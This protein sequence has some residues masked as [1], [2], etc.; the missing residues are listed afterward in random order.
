MFLSWMFLLFL[1]KP[2]DLLTRDTWESI[3]TIFND[4]F[5]F[6]RLLTRALWC[7]PVS[8]IELNFQ[9]SDKIIWK[10]RHSS[11]YCP[12]KGFSLH[13]IND[14]SVNGL[15]FDFS[16]PTSGL[17]YLWECPQDEVDCRTT[18]G[19]PCRNG[20]LPVQIWIAD[21]CVFCDALYRIWQGL[22]TFGILM[23]MHLFK[24]SKLICSSFMRFIQASV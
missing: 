9:S 24:D 14:K 1:S 11:Y 21:S 2:C 8:V 3:I 15:E 7:R 20:F 6:F 13:N 10:T 19:K 18:D 22:I 23:V 12:W 5:V 16:N 17:K 4:F